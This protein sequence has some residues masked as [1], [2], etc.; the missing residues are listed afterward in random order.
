MY[1]A[2]DLK[3][4]ERKSKALRISKVNEALDDGRR[5]HEFHDGAEEQHQHRQVRPRAPSSKWEQGPIA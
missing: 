5:L 3:D 2:G 4:S 1:R